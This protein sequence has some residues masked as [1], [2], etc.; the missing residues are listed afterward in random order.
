MPEKTPGQRAYAAYTHVM[1]PLAPWG[2][3]DYEALP[4]IHRAAW[5]AA[6]QAVLVETL[7]HWQAREAA[8]L[9]HA[10][11]VVRVYREGWTAP[12]LIQAVQE[13]EQWLDAHTEE[14]HG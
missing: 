4:D 6:A 14:Q 8:A 9:R 13:L 5:E 2:V 12:T 1:V 7:A 3:P 11:E 10:W